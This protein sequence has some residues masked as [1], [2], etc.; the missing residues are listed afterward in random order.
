ML[1][2]LLLGIHYNAKLYAQG[3]GTSFEKADKIGTFS[4]FFDLRE[5]TRG[6]TRDYNKRMFVHEEL[7]Y[8]FYDEFSGEP[9]KEFL[10][11]GPAM[12]FKFNIECPMALMVKTSD[13]P[14]NMNGVYMHVAVKRKKKYYV[15]YSCLGKGN[16]PLDIITQFHPELLYNGGLN[17]DV[18]VDLHPDEYYIIIS[19]MG[20]RPAS[21]NYGYMHVSFTGFPIPSDYQSSANYLPSLDPNVVP[22][23]PEGLENISAIDD[24]ALE[25]PKELNLSKNIPYIYGRTYTSQDSSKYI[26]N[27]KY[28]DGLG[29]VKQVVDRNITPTFKDLVKVYD[30]DEKDRI[31]RESLPIRVS[32]N[33]EGSYVARHEDHAS[34]YYRDSAYIDM[35]YEDL[36]VDRG[37][38]VYA[39]GATYKDWD[40][41]PKGYVQSISEISKKICI[42]K[43]SLSSI[44]FGSDL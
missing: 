41:V 34:G 19:G 18:S 5:L 35:I 37:V 32:G 21:V 24:T 3:P 9:A 17:L 23:K 40:I 38:K 28:Y 14:P 30:Y 6:T 44:R 26:E 4:S 2:A 11:E 31:I 10:G 12:Y 27:I 42:F 39:P 8:V 15:I 22:V 1:G 7:N 36:Y 13:I 43:F 16:L 25:F 33:N 20:I 29:R